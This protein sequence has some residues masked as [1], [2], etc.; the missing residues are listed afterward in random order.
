MLR[1][2]RLGWVRQVINVR[3][4]D[5]DKT[6]A[7]DDGFLDIDS[8]HMHD[9]SISSFGVHIEGEFEPGKLNAWLSRLM[10]E[11][12]ADLYR[13]KGILAVAGTDEKYVFQGVHMLLNMGSTSE[14]GMAHKP[15][16][17]DE[18]RL[19]KFCFIGKN[20]DKA[21]MMKDLQACM[22]DGKAPDP[23]PVP[24]TKLTYPIGAR[25]KCKV[26]KWRAG[27]VIK[28]WYREMFWETGRYA[29]Y[30]V[31]LDGKKDDE[32]LIYV[33]RDS[34]AFIKPESEKD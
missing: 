29:P 22:F 10:K 6:L 26:D 25:V 27:T 8:E 24:T 34:R 13:S 17:P 14:M 20:L 28:H 5:L 18:K 16:Q 3:A 2:L 33:P 9:S 11:K 4:F 21:E 30:Q 7:M 23:G 12:G 32:G 15:W 31:Q 1:A 19:N